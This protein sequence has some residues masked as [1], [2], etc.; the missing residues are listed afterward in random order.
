MTASKLWT[1]KFRGCYGRLVP[2]FSLWKVGKISLGDAR[3]YL[4]VRVTGSYSLDRWTATQVQHTWFT[5][6]RLF[7]TKYFCGSDIFHDTFVSKPGFL[8]TKYCYFKI[9]PQEG[10]LADKYVTNFK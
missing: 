4:P 6:H 1:W 7:C 9:F 10:Q 3:R 8:E 5:I 2:T